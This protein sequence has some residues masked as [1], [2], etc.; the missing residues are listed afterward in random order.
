MECPGLSNPAEESLLQWAEPRLGAAAVG[1][2]VLMVSQGSGSFVR[3][4]PLR[5]PELTVN[6]AGALTSC[7]RRRNG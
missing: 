3:G 4:A 5:P 7:G 1:L 2:A 6:A